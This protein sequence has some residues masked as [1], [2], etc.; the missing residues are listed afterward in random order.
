ML[1]YAFRDGAGHWYGDRHT[2]TLDGAPGTG[3]LHYRPD[4]AAGPVGP[5]AGQRLSVLYGPC[6]L[7][8]GG[9]ALRLD[10]GI[11]VTATW[12]VLELL[13]AGPAHTASSAMG[14]DDPRTHQ[15]TLGDRHY[16]LTVHGTAIRMSACTRGG[17]LL[18]EL[19]GSAGQSDFGPLAQLLSAAAQPAPAVAAADPQQPTPHVRSGH[20]AGAT[21]GDTAAPIDC[22]AHPSRWKPSRSGPGNTPR[23]PLA[24]PEQRRPAK[25]E[26]Q[27]SPHLDE[28]RSVYPKAY[29]PWLPED[30]DQ[31]R[32]RAAQGV[33]FAELVGE[34]GRQP[35]AIV[36]RLRKIHATGPVVDQMNEGLLP[37][38]PY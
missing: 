13:A 29:T 20:R 6:D 22:G 38:E 23:S 19:V 10:D 14:S 11:T 2:P 7:D 18:A 15:L 17:E 1:L 36:S 3:T 8:A 28:V 32:M 33:T 16:R 30:D 31:L 34:F 25:Q 5:F 9:P 37:G 4:P 24:G 26:Q 27:T 12:H 21:P 35:G